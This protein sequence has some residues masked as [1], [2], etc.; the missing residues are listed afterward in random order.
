MVVVKMLKS[1]EMLL[2]MMEP[3]M[4]EPMENKQEM[5]AVKTIKPVELLVEMMEPNM[6]K[7]MEK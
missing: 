2:G 6:T 1:V 5:L 7:P 4:T 3:N